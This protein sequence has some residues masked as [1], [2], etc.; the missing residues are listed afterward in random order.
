ML[1]VCQVEYRK[2]PREANRSQKFAIFKMTFFL[3]RSAKRG[4][5]RPLVLLVENPRPLQHENCELLSLKLE[6]AAVPTRQV[7]ACRAAELAC[8]IH[9]Q[10]LKQ[11]D[12]SMSPWTMRQAMRV[13]RATKL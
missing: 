4:V 8:K 11:I 13:L 6:V 3:L 5:L 1:T 2:P 10:T 7:G 9:V 12:Y